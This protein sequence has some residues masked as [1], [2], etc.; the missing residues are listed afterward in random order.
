MLTYT[1]TQVLLRLESLLQWTTEVIRTNVFRG[2]QEILLNHD[3]SM[4]TYV[5]STDNEEIFSVPLIVFS[6]VKDNRFC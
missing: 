1:H 6:V 3:G 5:F 4:F 2:L